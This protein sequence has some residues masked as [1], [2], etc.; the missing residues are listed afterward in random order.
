MR[1]D[2]VLKRLAER[3]VVWTLGAVTA[4]IVG[5]AVVVGLCGCSTARP[6]VMEKTVART[7]TLYRERVRTD[8]VRVTDSVRVWQWEKGDTVF[9]EKT[10][11]R[12]R[13]RVTVRTDTVYRYV[14]AR[15]SARVEQPFRYK[16][17]GTGSILEN[18]VE[19]CLCAM[20]LMAVGVGVALMI[21]FVLSKNNKL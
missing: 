11:W 4:G 7:D 19:D 13:D 20:G 12:W 5:A 1:N 2:K 6:V 10:A 15:D 17:T 18:F 21:T 9:V 16:D 8:T 3:L 14:A